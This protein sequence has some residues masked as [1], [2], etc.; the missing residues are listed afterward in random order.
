MGNSLKRDIGLWSMFTLG[1]GAM[2]GVGWIVMLG[3]WLNDAG[4]LGAI[5]AFVFGGLLIAGFAVCYAEVSASFPGTG[6]D[7]VFVHGIFGTPAAFAIGWLLLFVYAAVSGFLS[8]SAGWVLEAFVGPEWASLIDRKVAAIV[9]LLLICTLNVA[10]SK[11][12][13]LVQSAATYLLIFGALVFIV[14]GIFRG[15]GD[16][17]QPL[18]AG[19]TSGQAAHGILAVFVTTPLWYAGFNV[20]P[21]AMGERSENVKPAQV[22]YA[23]LL[24]IIGA[25]V[26][27]V[28]ILF[29]GALAAPRTTLMEAS[30]PA[31]VAFSAALGSSTAGKLVLLAGFLGLVTSWNAVYFAGGRV[32]YTLS[33]VKLLPGAFD[34]VN[35]KYGSPS[36][37]LIAIG[38]VS[39]FLVAFGA[40]GIESL[41]NASGT[42]FSLL[43]MIA[44]LSALKLRHTPNS[45][46]NPFKV[47]FGGAIAA[48]AVVAG[49]GVTLLSLWN[50]RPRGSEIISSEWVVLALWSAIGTFTWFAM[51]SRRRSLSRNARHQMLI[52]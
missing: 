3:A 42:G 30:L 7:I 13:V 18:F 23:M 17:L 26:F 47:K 35:T 51:T 48:C 46:I 24:G 11:W 12:A 20:V 16:N 15:D 31:A 28:A 27:Y 2:I 52:R 9:G 32:L 10:G 33:T 40:D 43:F 49:L 21:Q 44:A 50:T 8:L 4:S 37:A 45:S 25:I 39:V 29:S 19:S 36:R 22:V 41:A 1:F 38:A 34:H 14:F 5:L 6:G